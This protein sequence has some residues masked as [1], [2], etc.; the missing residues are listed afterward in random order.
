MV[1]AFSWNQLHD[2]D[3]MWPVTRQLLSWAGD[4]M[5]EALADTGVAGRALVVDGN[6]ADVLVLATHGHRALTARTLGSTRPRCVA[7]MH[8]SRGTFGPGMVALGA[9]R[10]RQ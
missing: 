10:W 5:G 4:L 6:A 7:G 8:A 9:A 2:P 1:H 3:L